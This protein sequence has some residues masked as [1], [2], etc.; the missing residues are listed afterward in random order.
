M[1]RIRADLRALGMPANIITVYGSPASSVTY[2]ALYMAFAGVARK[3]PVVFLDGGNSFN[4]YLIAKLARRVELHPE[5]LLSRIYLSRAFT[6]HQMQALITDR[7]EGALRKYSTNVAIV[8]G[9]LD[10]FFDQ[11]VPFAEAHA[12]LK[13]AA[14]EFVRL[15]GRGAHI[16]LACPDTHLPLQ[17]RQQ[18]FLQL[19]K[20]TSQKVLY[21]EDTKTESRFIM[22]KP[23]KKIYARRRIAA[24][25]QQFLQWR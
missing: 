1:E 16:L 21:C 11:D 7:L 8:S 10:T 24:P 25:S 4:P 5:E 22:E 9:L 6:C 2:L 20:K 18:V 13:S 12:L 17:S 15:A 23:H 14:A 19:L 3:T